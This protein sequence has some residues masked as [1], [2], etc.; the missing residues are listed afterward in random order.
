MSDVET[1]SAVEPVAIQ[2]SPPSAAETKTPTKLFEVPLEVTG[3]R[4][5]SKTEVFKI[6]VNETVKF[7]VVE[8]KGIA[9]GDIEKV[10]DNLSEHTGDELLALYSVCFGRLRC[11]ENLVKKHLKL[12]SGFPAD[13]DLEKREAHLGR[14]FLPGLKLSCG[15]LGLERGGTKEEIIER[16]MEFCKKPCDKAAKAKTPSKKTPSKKTPSKKTPSK[17]SSK[18][19]KDDEE[20]K[21]K[22][23]KKGSKPAPKKALD[24]PAKK[25]KASV[26]DDDDDDDNEPLVKKTKV[27][28]TDEALEQ[29]VKDILSKSDL[30]KVTKKSVREDVAE[31]F[32]ASDLSERKEFLNACIAKN[33]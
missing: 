8:G 13:T 29:A 17:K 26:S 30:S 23:S 10:L 1:T 9:L 31:L 2:G 3:K 21:P 6:G 24:I 25:R 7:E 12:F 20:D 18:A 14:M 5:R 15:V 11:K 32:P 28:P 19:S 4:E 33:I 16:L 22:S 27:A